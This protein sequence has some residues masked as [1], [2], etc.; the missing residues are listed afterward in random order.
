MINNMPC[1]Q[2]WS[3]TRLDAEVESARLTARADV[4]L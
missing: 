4:S 2:L 1:D 3:E